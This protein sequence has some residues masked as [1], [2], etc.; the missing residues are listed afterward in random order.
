MQLYI[1]TANLESIK[2]AI[3][4]YPISGVTTNPSLLSKEKPEDLFGHLKMIQAL[5]GPDRDLHVQVIGTSY[6]AIL[7]DAHTIT[8]RLGK[9]VYIKI[10]ATPIGLKAIRTLKKEG[11][12]ITA[13]AIYSKLQA[14][15][16]VLSRA[17]YIAPYINRMANLDINPYE[18]LN[19][20]NQFILTEGSESKIIA[21]SFKNL[22]QVSDSIDCGIDA[23]TIDPKLLDEIFNFPS[24]SK[25]VNDFNEDF[26]SIYGKG[27]TLSKLK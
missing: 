9:A 3:D 27:M 11:L 7:E 14:H 16:A 20:M 2:K 8:H 4:L 10:P 12:K 24:L 26:E 6:E 23:L 15:L 19:S 21:A 18:S 5:I 13:T 17:D 25:S 22:S 1:D